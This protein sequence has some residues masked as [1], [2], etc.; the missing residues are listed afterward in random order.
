MNINKEIENLGD[1]FIE[2]GSRIKKYQ[3]EVMA[4][5]IKEEKEQLYSITEVEKIYPKLSKYI[6]TKAINEG[7]L[8]VTFIG[9]V[10]H[11]YLKD[12]DAFL[13]RSRQQK[14][15]PNSFTSWRTSESQ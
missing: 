11:F 5:K 12:I 8:P 3:L 2:F 7:Q 10:R 4:E 9:N 15:N 1:I 13:E 6:L 14:L